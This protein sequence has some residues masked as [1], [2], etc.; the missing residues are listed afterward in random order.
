LVASLDLWILRVSDEDIS[1]PFLYN[2]LRTD[3]YVNYITGY[4]SG[5]TVLHLSK[6]GIPNYKFVKPSVPI[7][8]VFNKLVKPIY[9]Q[10][11]LNDNE[12]RT[13]AN[14][15]DALLPHLFSGALRVKYT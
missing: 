13:L 12:T 5:T 7:L 2:L 14:I 6:D 15:R 8:R 1:V 10:L 4:A 11:M 3:D 9:E